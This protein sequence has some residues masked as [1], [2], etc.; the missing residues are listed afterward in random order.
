MELI[1]FVK[2]NSWA[3]FHKTIVE[4]EQ[5]FIYFFKLI[6]ALISEIKKVWNYMIKNINVLYKIY[7]Y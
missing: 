3:E 1:S 4:Q 5:A 6:D 2:R 7:K